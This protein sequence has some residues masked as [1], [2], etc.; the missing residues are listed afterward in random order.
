M[1]PLLIILLVIPIILLGR[2]KVLYSKD[3]LFKWQEIYKDLN[4]STS[5]FYTNVEDRILAYKIPNQESITT[6]LRN[7]GGRISSRR[8]YLCVSYGHFRVY[9]CSGH[10]GTS[11]FFS[12]RMVRKI[13]ILRWIILK[14]P[15]LGT[16]LGNYGQKETFYR[17]DAQYS[18]LTII[19][20]CVHEE[21]E[22]Q[23]GNKVELPPKVNV[24]RPFLKRVSE[25]RL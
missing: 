21:I 13:S 6:V 7:E 3:E 22:S 9:I 24:D 8:Q 15:I 25:R 17:S 16:L 23:T 11:N 12:I 4:I 20:A 18:A 14:T 10:F 5:E 2:K 19:N 1:G